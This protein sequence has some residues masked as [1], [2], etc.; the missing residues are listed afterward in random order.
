MR[1]VEEPFVISMLS[2]AV[3][4]FVLPFTIVQNTASLGR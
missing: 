2:S 3:K 1:H 4:L